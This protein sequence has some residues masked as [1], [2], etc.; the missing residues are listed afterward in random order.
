MDKKQLSQDYIDGWNACVTKMMSSVPR[1]ERKIVLSRDQKLERS[2]NRYNGYLKPYLPE[3]AQMIALGMT[4]REIASAIVDRVDG[5]NLPDY[6]QE[7]WKQRFP[8]RGERVKAI[9]G[10][11]GALF[12]TGT[13]WRTTRRCPQGPFVGKPIS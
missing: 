10:M 8:T 2:R 3:I 6:S 13:A 1:L 5:P 11:I 9:V 7:D 12:K 4:R